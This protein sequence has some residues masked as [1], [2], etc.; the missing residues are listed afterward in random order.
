MLIQTYTIL[1]EALEKWPLS[2][3]EEIVPPQLVP[4]IEALDAVAKERSTNE[5]SQS[6]IIIAR[7]Y[8]T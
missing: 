4:I 3:L 1:A 7:S 5:K 2:Y 6:L 8:G